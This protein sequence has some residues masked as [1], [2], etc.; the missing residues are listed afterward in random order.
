MLRA[1]VSIYVESHCETVAEDWGV[2]I[3]KGETPSEVACASGEQILEL[4]RL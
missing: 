2:D 3:G 4:S 1:H